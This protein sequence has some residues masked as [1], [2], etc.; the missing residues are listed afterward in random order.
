MY[1]MVDIRKE[2]Y[3]NNDLEVIVDDIGTLWLHEKHVEEKLGHENFPV[4]TNKFYPV[5]KKHRYE[6]VDK[7]KEQPNRRFLRSNLALKVIMDRRTDESCNLKRNLGFKLHD[8]INTKEQTVINSIKDEFETKDIQTQYSVLGYRID[9]YFH[10][11]KLAIEVDKL[12][13]AGRNRCHGIERQKALEKEKS[14][15]SIKSKCLKWIVKKVLTV[16]KE[17][18]TSDQK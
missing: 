5:Y 4:I 10:K 18:K 8:L 6:L 11:H 17:W 13:H 1:K 9:I 3:E 2:L 16:C 15:H 14:N 12:G 7:P